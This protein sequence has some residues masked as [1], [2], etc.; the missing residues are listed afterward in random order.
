MRFHW[1]DLHKGYLEAFYF[2]SLDNSINKEKIKFIP[3]VSD[4]EDIRNLRSITLLNV[5]YKIIAKA[6][7]L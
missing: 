2:K 7:T 5:S 6:S 4:P 3:K 1:V